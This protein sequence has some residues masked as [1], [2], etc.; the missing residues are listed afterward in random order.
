M[1]YNYFIAQKVFER[2]WKKNEKAYLEAG[3][4]PEAIAEI[5]EFDWE[6]FKATRIYELHTSDLPLSTDDEFYNVPALVAL[7]PHAQVA[8]QDDAVNVHSRYWW[9][10]DLEDPRLAAIV[11]RLSEEDKE[12][13]TQYFVEQCT[14]EEIALRL[15]TYQRKVSRR[16]HKIFSFLK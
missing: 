1:K 3:M 2:E 4:T 16:L 14:E 15:G 11:P 12:I 13:L 6:V 8:T 10:D 7:C 9:I 5:R